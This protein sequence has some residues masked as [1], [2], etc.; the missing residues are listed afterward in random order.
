MEQMQLSPIE[1]FLKWSMRENFSALASVDIALRD[2]Q[3][4]LNHDVLRKGFGCDAVTSTI[5]LNSRLFG[6]KRSQAPFL[7]TVFPRTR[8]T[9]EAELGDYLEVHAGNPVSSILSDKLPC[10][11]LADGEDYLFS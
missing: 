4:H 7:K 6:L 3:N 5:L 2:N 8:V 1:K 10:H 11:R 9:F